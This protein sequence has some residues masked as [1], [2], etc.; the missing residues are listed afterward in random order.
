MIK[1]TVYIGLCL[2]AW[3][4]M[5]GCRSVEKSVPVEK[6]C[7]AQEEMTLIVASET[8]TGHGVAPMT[9]LL[10]KSVPQEKWRYMYSRIEGFVYEPGYE[11]RIVV[12]RSERDQKPQDASAYTYKLIRILSKEKKV[13]EGMP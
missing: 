2:L 4:G 6:T 12:L 5:Q 11:Y 10:I 13:S 8:R 1:K 3:L 9:C 7:A